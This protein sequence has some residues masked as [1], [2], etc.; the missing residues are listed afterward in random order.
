MKPKNAKFIDQKYHGLTF[1]KLVLAGVVVFLLSKHKCARH[2]TEWRCG[3]CDGFAQLPICHLRRS[4]Y[5]DAFI[6]IFL[7][8]PPTCNFGKKD[9]AGNQ[10]KFRSDDPGLNYDENSVW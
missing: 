7:F 5:G 8:G 1:A 6:A 3:H 10:I 2:I 4:V 9:V